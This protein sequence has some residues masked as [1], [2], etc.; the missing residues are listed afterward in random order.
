MVDADFA[1]ITI[2]KAQDGFNVV[3]MQAWRADRRVESRFL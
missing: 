3:V 2:V 1:R